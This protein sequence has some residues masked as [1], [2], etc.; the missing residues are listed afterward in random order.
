VTGWAV[1]VVN[2]EAIREVLDTFQRLKQIRRSLPHPLPFWLTHHTPLFGNGR[3]GHAKPTQSKNTT[4]QKP[5]NP[6]KASK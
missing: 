1:P 5:I 3:D 2:M 4:P 6:A